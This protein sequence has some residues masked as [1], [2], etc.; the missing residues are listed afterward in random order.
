MQTNWV[1]PV[2]FYEGEDPASFKLA[3][4]QY[5]ARHP[6]VSDFDVATKVFE[7]TEHSAQ[8]IGQ[9]AY[10]W[11]RDLDVL[12]AVQQLRRGGLDEE[13]TISKEQ[14][15]A[16]ILAIARNDV[17]IETKER[18]N[19]YKLVAEINGFVNKSGPSVALQINR[20][21]QVRDHGSD[22]D[23]EERAKAQQA[24]LV[25]GSSHGV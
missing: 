15:S 14:L 17:Q 10:A 13:P 16:E 11:G 21:M 19:A 12:E 25:G 4:I 3:F 9:A 2:T 20:V 7:G 22:D 23:W 1:Q 8:R 24:R 18:L 6:T 5:K